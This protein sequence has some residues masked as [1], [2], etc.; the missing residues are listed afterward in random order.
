MD[1]LQLE[2]KRISVM[3]KGLLADAP[4]RSL[5]SS[6]VAHNGTYG[7]CKCT[8]KG[9]QVRVAVECRGRMTFPD[10][11]APTRNDENFQS[12]AQ[13]EHHKPES[14]FSKII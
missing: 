6:S 11:N 4:A 1:G 14:L 7:C 5:S 12:R 13:P 8:T 2:H 10:I 9:I 3:T